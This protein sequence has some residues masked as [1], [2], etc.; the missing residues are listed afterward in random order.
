M[1]YDQ[2]GAECTMGRKIPGACQAELKPS[3]ERSE[4]KKAQRLLHPSH[5]LFTAC[6]PL[7]HKRAVPSELEIP[8]Q[9]HKKCPQPFR[10][11]LQL[12]PLPLVTSLQTAV[13]C[14][15]AES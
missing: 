12:P 11:Q 5:P 9:F 4:H 13:I 7:T 6:F 10:D 15:G 3:T 2:A 1:V 8:I 14:P